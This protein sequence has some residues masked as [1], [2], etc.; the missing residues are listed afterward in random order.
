MGWFGNKQHKESSKSTSRPESSSARGTSRREYSA[1][2]PAAAATTKSPGSSIYANTAPTVKATEQSI[3]QEYEQYSQPEYSEDVEEQT[4]NENTMAGDHHRGVHDDRR[5]VADDDEMIMV[6]KGQAHGEDY[7]DASRSFSQAEDTLPERA[8]FND[9]S[10]QNHLNS[11][12]NGHLMKWK[13]EAEEG[14]GFIRIPACT[15]SF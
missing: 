12:F 4:Q 5:T 6:D 9:T 7:E 3:H 1:P 8:S 11:L 10:K 13:F 14:S 2:A 15:F